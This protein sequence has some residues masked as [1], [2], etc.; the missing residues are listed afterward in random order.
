MK[1]VVAVVTKRG[2][3]GVYFPN[4]GTKK[5]FV[6]VCYFLDNYHKQLRVRE[7][8]CGHSRGGLVSYIREKAS[9]R[10]IVA[11]GAAQ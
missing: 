5:V 10:G 11:I 9:A 2:K 4:F 1:R 3:G 8:V 7:R 6:C